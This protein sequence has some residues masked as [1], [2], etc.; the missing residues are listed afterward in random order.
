MALLAALIVAGTIAFGIWKLTLEP[1]VRYGQFLRKV[2]WSPRCLFPPP[3]GHSF[4]FPSDSEAVL[5]LLKSWLAQAKN[6]LLYIWLG[7]QPIMII[8]NADVTEQVLRSP[9]FNTKGFMYNFLL[10]WLH[11]GLLT[12]TG[13]K[14][15]RRRKLLTPAF[16]FAILKSYFETMKDQV[17]VLL[18]VI[19]E[20]GPKPIDARELITNCTLDVIC[21]TAMGVHPD[22]QRSGDNNPYVA[23]VK[24]S[25]ELILRRMTAPLLWPDWLY[26]L[27]P[28]GQ[29]LKRC[30]RILHHYTRKAILDRQEELA[31][32]R[33]AWL[34]HLEN[35]GEDSDSEERESIDGKLPLLDLLIATSLYS[36]AGNGGGS[37]SQSKDP[38]RMMAQ[39][40]DIKGIQEEVDTFMFEGHDTTANALIWAL[41]RI[42]EAPQVQQKIHDELDAVFGQNSKTP[43]AFDD[44]SR[45]DYLEMVIKEVLRLYPPVPMLQRRV[46]ADTPLRING[47]NL[48]V[49]RGMQITV[50]PY[51]LH[52]D[53]RHFERPDEFDPERFSRESLN[54]SGRHPYSYVP[55]SAGPRNCIGQKF[56]LMEE[57]MI[58]AAILRNYRIVAEQATETIG[59]KPDL[60]LRPKRPVLIKFLSRPHLA[61]QL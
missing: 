53:E 44:L 40:L 49:P 20:R 3:I 1:L 7:A 21:E 50:I 27:T 58:L 42:A 61:S 60:I 6:G 5:E 56:A 47:E 16:H 13:E 26:H 37:Q 41:Q 17:E 8:T 38:L 28:P 48:M 51:L 33:P 45:L 35:D 18:A 43:V 52:R 55:F 23:A 59:L 29:E 11:T 32:V 15:R 14:W 46:D 36:E 9:H 25:N 19:R 31:R 24:R 57:K 10:P 39:K 54:K 4:Q 12:S 22:A 2:G 30:L 34:S